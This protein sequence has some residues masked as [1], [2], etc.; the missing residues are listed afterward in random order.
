[1]ILGRVSHGGVWERE[2]ERES[3]WNIWYCD[4][5]KSCF[6][7]RTSWSDRESKG[8]TIWL[9]WVSSQTGQKN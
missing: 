5:D 2:R 8:A 7:N 9:D 4:Y 6:K 1:M 3:E